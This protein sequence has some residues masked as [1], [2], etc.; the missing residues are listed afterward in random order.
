MSMLATTLLMLWG[1]V[2]AAARSPALCLR[3]SEWDRQH[4][5]ER[6]MINRTQVLR[7]ITPGG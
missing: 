6:Q 7:G 2:E 1:G 3:K 4:F 5:E